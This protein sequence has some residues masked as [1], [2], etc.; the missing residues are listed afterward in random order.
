MDGEWGFPFILN[1]VHGDSHNEE[2]TSKL[3]ES[4]ESNINREN[5]A[6][7]FCAAMKLK[8]LNNNNKKVAGYNKKQLDV[9]LEINNSYPDVIFKW[10]LC[11]LIAMAMECKCRTLRSISQYNKAKLKYPNMANA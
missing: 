5:V 7:A 2:F 4:V 3:R 1:Y 6:E 9:L 8:E 10:D 11:N